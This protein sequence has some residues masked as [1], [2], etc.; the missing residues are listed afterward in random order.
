M[1]ESLHVHDY[2]E[3]KCGEIAIDG[4][5]QYHKTFARDYFNFLRV[6]DEGNE[7]I[8]TVRDHEGPLI[9]NNPKPSRADLIE[10]LNKMAEN[11]DSLP[12]HAKTSFVTQY[13]LYA[14]ITLLGLIFKA[15][16]SD[17]SNDQCS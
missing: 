12:P 3:C 4:G 8:V 14:L 10:M 11:I 17:Q 9:E 7:I 5:D 1:I 2:V 6:D 15:S 13:D 16:N